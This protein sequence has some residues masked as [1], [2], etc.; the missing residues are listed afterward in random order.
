M[1]KHAVDTGYRRCGFEKCME[2][3]RGRKS[4]F[5]HNM[6][7]NVAMTLY[8]N[9]RIATKL[10]WCHPWKKQST[11]LQPATTAS[12]CQQRFHVFPLNPFCSFC[13][14][15]RNPAASCIIPANP[16]TRVSSAW[17]HLCRACS[18]V[19]PGCCFRTCGL[20][21]LGVEAENGRRNTYVRHT[22]VLPKV[23]PAM[24][25][26]GWLDAARRHEILH[27]YSS[28]SRG[29]TT[30]TVQGWIEK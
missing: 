22:K 26:R 20:Q 6:R 12:N 18:Q 2:L 17:P 5:V 4:Y 3:E 24:A 9:N 8:V 16:A 10:V 21:R 30:P 11:L 7:Q 28:A 23:R 14:N 27:K 19:Q 15:V 13:C 25:P 29:R 1:P